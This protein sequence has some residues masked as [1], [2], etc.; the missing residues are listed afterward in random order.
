VGCA[1]GCW[2][3]VSDRRQGSG[4]GGGGG[5]GNDMC[6]PVKRAQLG[7]GAATRKKYDRWC[8]LRALSLVI[9]ERPVLPPPN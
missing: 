3:D 8:S 1:V 9:G 7:P 2:M 4:G 6:E 5:G